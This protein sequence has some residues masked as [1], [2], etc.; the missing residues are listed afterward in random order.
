MP[1]IQIAT[2]RA[3]VIE[4][5]PYGESDTIVTLLGEKTGRTRA[6]AKGARKSS[7]RFAGGLEITDTGTFELKVPAQPDQLWVVQSISQR[8]AW[9]QLRANLRKFEI[10]SYCLE[11]AGKFAAEGDPL[12][13]DLFEPLIDILNRLD[14]APNRRVCNVLA[15][16]FT[17]TVLV[18]EGLNPLLSDTQWREEIFCWWER[19]LIEQCPLDCETAEIARD[20][21][22]YLIQYTENAIGSQLKTGQ[23][24]GN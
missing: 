3:T 20:G 10:A 21:L 19:M 2:T 16:Y 17:L 22:R 9:P 8:F 23:F 7:R 5:M 14:A 4:A 12:A 6:I 13:K 18:I 1:P 15:V 24:A 11:I